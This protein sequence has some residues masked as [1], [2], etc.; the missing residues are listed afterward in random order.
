MS[1]VTNTVSRCYLRKEAAPNLW[2]NMN[3]QSCWSKFGTVFLCWQMY[4]DF[5]FLWYV[6]SG[7]KLIFFLLCVLSDWKFNICHENEILGTNHG[8]SHFWFLPSPRLTWYQFYG[9]V[10]ASLSI[11]STDGTVEMWW[12]R[13][14]W[15]E[16][17]KHIFSKWHF[18]E[19]CC[20][21][22]QL[23]QPKYIIYLLKSV[24]VNQNGNVSIVFHL[25]CFNIVRQAHF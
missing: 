16:P 18:Y 12:C 11:V 6:F 23:L 24:Q 14:F 21:L 8:L 1:C 5:F 2:G 4:V 17:W 20:K 9:I 15:I 22:H 25:L 19:T 3:A 10:L 13:A 7:C